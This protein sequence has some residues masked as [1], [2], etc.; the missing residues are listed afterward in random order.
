MKN[1]NINSDS[2]TNKIL[3]KNNNKNNKI[4]TEENIKNLDTIIENYKKN[5]MRESH[6]YL[7]NTISRKNKMIKKK[8][9]IFYKQK[10][11]KK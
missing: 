9:M 6:H 2:F 7:E 10:I 8:E 11:I 1:K 5:N 4:N 3:N